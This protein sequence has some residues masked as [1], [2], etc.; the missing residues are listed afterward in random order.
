MQFVL[1]DGDHIIDYGS[2]AIFQRVC[3]SVWLLHAWAKAGR[4]EAEQEDVS[5]WQVDGPSAQAWLIGQELPSIYERHFNRPFGI[6]KP[7]D[8]SGPPGGPGIR[9]VQICAE[10]LGFEM[11]PWAIEKAWDRYRKH[12]T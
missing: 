2:D 12:G 3:E 10:A 1:D 4:E 9:F 11:T 5:H 8:G 6:S 7:H